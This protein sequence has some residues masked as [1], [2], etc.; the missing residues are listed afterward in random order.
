MKKISKISRNSKM[1]AAVMAVSMLASSQVA[2]AERS[3]GVDLASPINGVYTNGSVAATVSGLAAKGSSK[4]TAYTEVSD[5]PGAT[6]TRTE[7]FSRANTYDLG[8]GGVLLST[9]ETE[10][11]GGNF[12]N[13]TANVGGAIYS[14]NNLTIN[15]NTVFSNNLTD[16]YEKITHNYSAIHYYDADK[17]ELTDLA[18]E[19]V[20]TGTTSTMTTIGLMGGAIYQKDGD[21][22]IGSD[23]SF[24]NNYSNG[25][26]GA[27]YAS[28]S[29]ITT[30]ADFTNNSGTI[31]GALYVSGGSLTIEDGSSFTG[32]I[33]RT[34][35]GGGA[36][37]ADKTSKVEIGDNVVFEG[38]KVNL[39]SS[40]G[41]AIRAVGT[42]S[43]INAITLGDNVQFKNNSIIYASPEA[44]NGSLGGAI[45]LD[46]YT[47]LD[48]GTNALFE[49]NSADLGGAIYM[50]N[51]TNELT[52][53]NATFK[54]NIG[55][56]GGGALYIGNYKTGGTIDLGSSTFE[57]NSTEQQGGAINLGVNRDMIIGSDV[58]FVGNSAV[59]SESAL[60]G[61]LSVGGSY[62]QKWTS[63]PIADESVKSVTI[64]GATFE[65]NKTSY[66]DENGMYWGDGGAIGQAMVTA[67][68]AK[69]KRYERGLNINVNEGTTFTNNI[70]G[71][72]GG[73]IS[74]D[75]HLNINGATFTGNKT[76]GTAIGTDLN[77]SNEGGGAIFMYDDSVASITNS[78]FTNNESGTWG[79]AISTRGVSN[80]ASGANSTL[81]ISDSSFT[82]NVAKNGNGG[83]IA[84]SIN[85]TINATNSDVVFTGNKAGNNPNDIY[86]SNTA[87]SN[88]LLTLNT[89]EGKTISM[90][91]G[92][93][94]NRAYNVDMTGSGTVEISGS[95]NRANVSVKG[96][97]FHLSEG[98]SLTNS[99]V[100]VDSGAIM[101]TIDNA[102]NDYTVDGSKITLADGAKVMLDV[103]GTAGASNYDRLVSEGAVNVEG[104]NV[105]ANISGTSE[106]IQIAGGNTVTVADGIK[107]VTSTKTYDVTAGST[108]DTIKLTENGT[109]GLN[110]AVEDTNAAKRETVVYNMTTDE[111]FQAT[112]T[113]KEDTIQKAT[114]IIHGNNNTVEAASGAVGMV[115]DENSYVSIDNVG[116]TSTNTDGFKNFEMTD[117]T[118]KGSVLTNKGNLTITNSVV[119]SNS[120][121]AIYNES[122]ARLYVSNSKFDGTGKVGRAIVNEGIYGN[123]DNDFD[124]YTTTNGAYKNTGSATLKGDHFSM[125]IANGTRDVDHG[126]GAIWNSGTL[127]IENSATRSSDFTGNTSTT[128]GGAIWNSGTLTVSD[129]NF[130][131]NSAFVVD[132]Q[133]GAIYSMGDVTINAINNAVA[134]SGNTANE[135]GD[136]YMSGLVANPLTLTLNAIDDT[137]TI[138]LGGGVAGQ[139]YNIYIN[140]DGVSVGTVTNSVAMTGVDN[141]NVVAG[142][143][144]N[145]GAITATSV[146]NSGT[147][148][149]NKTVTGAVSNSGTF[150][151]NAAGSVGAVTNSNGTFSNTGIVAS[152]NVTGGTFNNSNSLTGNVTVSSGATYN[153][154]SGATTGGTIQSSGTLTNSGTV[155]GAVSVL[156][157]TFTN[158]KDVNNDVTVSGT[159]SFSNLST[160]V[161]T[162]V[163]DNS[164]TVV[165]TGDIQG[166]IINRVGGTITSRTDTIA[167]NASSTIVNAGI[168][169]FTGGSISKDIDGITVAGV[170][171]YGTV[172]TVSGMS[173]G[174][175]V[176]VVQG[177]LDVT[178]TLNNAGSITVNDTLTNGGTINNTGSLDLTKDG[179]MANAGTINGGGDVTIGD[180][181]AATVLT[182]NGSIIGNIEVKSGAE[183]IT[184]TDTITDSNG[185]VNAGTLTLN[186]GTSALN[187]AVSGGGHTDIAGN[188]VSLG[189]KVSQ[190]INIL[191]GGKLTTSASNIGGDVN[192]NTGMLVL[193]G[194]NLT[195]K[196][197]NA[198]A[199]STVDIVAGTGGTVVV[200]DTG[201][202]NGEI[203]NGILKLTSGTFDLRYATDRGTG[204]D[205][206]MDLTGLAK[207]TAGGGILG[208]QDGYTGAIDLGNIDTTSNALIVNTDL[209]LVN[210]ASDVFSGT[211]TGST[212]N[213]I[214]LGSIRLTSDAGSKAPTD[215]KVAESSLTTDATKISVGSAVV[216]NNTNVGGLLLNTKYED[217]TG[218]L[219]QGIYM[220]VEHSDLDNA[221]KSNI[222]D[223]A[224]VMG[225]STIDN[226]SGALVLNGNKLSI[227][228]NGSQTI[229]GSTAGNDGINVNGKEL[230]INNT[231]M[232]GFGTAID[233][234]SVAGG[235]VNLNGLTFTGNTVDV[236][237]AGN[238]NLTGTNSVNTVT[239]A[240]G[241]TSV[242]SGSTTVAGAI[243]QATINVGNN[244]TPNDAS[245]IIGSG[246]ALTA[247]DLNV[248][249]ANSQFTNNGGTSGSPNSIS[250]T[251]TNLGTVSNTGYL[252]VGTVDNDNILT[253]SGTLSTTTGIDNSG[254]I[255]NN[256]TGVIQGGTLTNN[257]GTINN[258]AVGASIASAIDNKTGT[259]NTLASQVTGGVANDGTVNLT[260][261][262]TTT[263]MVLGSSIT[264]SSAATGTGIVNIVGNVATAT[265]GA[266][267]QI[268]EQANV[269]IGTVAGAP[270]VETPGTLVNAGSVESDNISITSNS[271]LSN[272][273]TVTTN[274]LLTNGGSISNTGVMNGS[275]SITNNNTLNNLGSI[276]NTINN[277]SGATVNNNVDT[278][279]SPSV[280]GSIANITNY[281]AFNNAGSVTGTLT[282]KAATLA[283][284]KVTNTGSIANAV[285]EAGGT[286]NNTTG[287]IGTLTNAGASGTTPAGVVNTYAGGILTSADNSGVLNINAGT[288][289]P[290]QST[291]VAAITDTAG[292]GVS[293]ITGSII[294]NAGITQKSVNIGTDDG[295][296]TVVI[297]SLA[298]NDDLFAD[299]IT[300]NAG[301]T[302]ANNDTIAASNGTSASA[303][304]VGANSEL[305]LNA[306]SVATA[307]TTLDNTTSKLTITDD[308]QLAGN[309]VASSG[310]SIKLVADQANIVLDN[311]ASSAITGTIAGATGAGSYTITATTADPAGADKAVTID[312]AIA[313]ATAV[314]V[315]NNTNATLTDKALNSLPATTSVSVGNG[316]ELTIDNTDA[317]LGA[318]LNVANAIAKATATDS[319]DVSITNS[320]NGTTNLNSTITGANNI[321]TSN[322]TTNIN[323]VAATATHINTTGGTTNIEVGIT[324]SDINT[325]GGT[326]NIEAGITVSDINTSGG[327]TNID[328]A[329]T[330]A[331]VNANGGVTNVN[332]M[333]GESKTS[334][335]LGAATINANGTGKV[336][337]NTNSTAMTIDNAV[338]STAVAPATAGS[339]ELNGV[340]GTARSASN[341]GT[342]FSV[343]SGTTI[344]QVAATL[345][346]GQLNLADESAL[347]GG[348]TLEVQA[349]ATL[350]AMNGGTSSFN[351]VTLDDNSQV[352]VDINA[353][354]GA[355]DKFINA[356]VNPTT[357]G[358]TITDVGLQD[359]NKVVHHTTKIDLSKATGLNN[360][361]IGDELLNKTFT[362]MTPI[363]YMTARITN[364]GV[365][366][367]LPSSGRNNYKDF[368]PA[369]VASPVATQLGGYL[370]QLNTYDQAFRN[371]D[372][373]MLLTKKQRQAIKLRNKYAAADGQL[374]FDPTMSA[375]DNA[376]AYVR[377]YATFES[378]PLKHG[379][380]VSNVSYGTFIGGES[381]LKDLGNG[382]DGMWG[383]Y[384]GY[385]GSHQAYDGI[386]IYQ[387]GGTLG[388]VG[389]AYKGDFFTGLTI[390][391]GA[392][393]GEAST[394]YGND[395]FSML[396][397]GI[398]SKTGYNFELAEGKL[399]IQPSFLT[400]YSFVN[401]FD[402]MNA[403]GVHI[404]TDALH[405]IQVE[406]GIK[407]IGNLKNGW[408]PYAGVSMVWNIMD[409][410]D[411]Y[412]NDIALPELSVKPFVKYGV[413]VRKTW[414]ERLSGFFQ[415]YFMSGGRR[416]VGLQMGFRWALGKKPA[417]NNNMSSKLPEQKETSI[418]MSGIKNN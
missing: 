401:T 257:G 25:S 340:A 47:T 163:L 326:T 391:A 80:G 1:L 241:I 395:N 242:N 291:I 323:N 328:T 324:A 124:N 162:G 78:E 293:N 362:E 82:G 363:R 239:G 284:D 117:D 396:M 411:F 360:I 248:R 336:A 264:D 119:K 123:D 285:N 164:K 141:L 240:T 17:H 228:G 91:G 68:N 381:E 156:A 399:I 6:Y 133:G 10:I 308:G 135:G 393:V 258:T 116:D 277:L 52:L 385:N 45:K 380:K 204:V 134:F 90:D 159:G 244:V 337:V 372:M 192:N 16:K 132:S 70:A 63:G 167:T 355:G 234:A 66:I 209:D 176:N 94:G 48:A 12:S 154:N 189:A 146:D 335:L 300:V 22:E 235:T 249:T 54:D 113:T 56:R 298:N 272:S 369:I 280:V 29:D 408:Q 87:T 213:G 60:G 41:G 253:N 144:V 343:A 236:A 351:L 103:E 127:V 157:G 207:I 251:L 175:G 69:Y 122:G 158:S 415:T 137:N 65:G 88:H 410:T 46:G 18:T 145:D 195:S 315:S 92:I 330:V 199:N 114:F 202:G 287:T 314:N 361:S 390:N 21:L 392:N 75:A 289:T 198:T 53:G 341:P 266:G 250:G 50:N 120:G 283:T 201:V 270:A 281:G 321:T 375:T 268:I 290:A 417:Q 347:T 160:G 412:A 93:D 109:G 387:N 76:L 49:G 278:S 98:S 42:S 299:T 168:L 187:T 190:N 404:N 288:G 35:T 227:S 126:G 320:G 108:G 153:N 338:T 311:S 112:S 184:N 121:D 211:F 365:M 245:L 384:A 305:K 83:A 403:A 333:G 142:T 77:D 319:F 106:E 304:E 36:I 136:I 59:G 7:T 177:T 111:T 4:Y 5:V 325:S 279:V 252:S 102:I 246:A 57:G 357:D 371:M 205:G 379:P 173:V 346:N 312:K 84:T 294:S 216:S 19:P 262:S 206:D 110:A 273:G 295:L 398:A 331:N 95:V 148:T 171:T 416:G 166:N 238:L 183:L 230:T 370:Q 182:N 267:S 334:D 342:V 44:S 178:G 161:V 61:A 255:T 231:S 150:N 74:S 310:G 376:G 9:I 203:S 3:G 254:T 152:A 188:N 247:T 14:T 129:A 222:S 2:M 79:G 265:T 214:S 226:S 354:S 232:S 271:T 223:K 309:V 402:Y 32:N 332:A 218:A 200:N 100:S 33:A 243:T 170:T 263:P 20:E 72:D 115:V 414:G 140:N 97:E 358:V 37:Y 23:V 180:G 352:K 418:D 8:Q 101:N 210:N 318:T 301:S 96:G 233:N 388:V 105:I 143:L 383:L 107:A 350:N 138:T 413:G 118:N 237:N 274:T 368:N 286:I 303:I 89:A 348:A 367:I 302:L 99:T 30:G 217:G 191:A 24:D 31:G 131:N 378:V 139:Y 373:Y 165:N 181:A 366:T 51:N 359:L 58:K 67:N 394:F 296:G 317:T 260:G 389:M 81:T 356:Q 149:N 409:K 345:K 400:S 256:A 405:A 62:V 169:D 172:K 386:S 151:N 179:A 374:V 229:T 196:I 73:A 185:L 382:W 125:N 344:D 282:N 13:N 197:T 329:V 40:Y 224:F 15:G 128:D 221:I 86:V 219:A 259:L 275:G 193:T 353:V 215:I 225:D 186:N 28:N 39:S 38:N 377:P 397:A 220:H 307:N 297:G 349:N 147:F 327:T 339:L 26:G 174:S 104:V 276:A 364:D 85:T 261:S 71:A 406:P 407:V 11:S 34:Q 313:G 208:L 306:N 55:K 130:T 43:Q 316:G 64:N 322:G 269:Y 292:T 212:V 194:G 27:I 155:S